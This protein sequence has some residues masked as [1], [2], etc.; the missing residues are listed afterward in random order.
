[1]NV[2]KV[3]KLNNEIIDRVDELRQELHP[4]QRRIAVLSNKSIQDMSVSELLA[5]A[6][7]LLE[8]TSDITGGH[9]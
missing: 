7:L 9:V 3:S 4:L 1:M 5:T 8:I 6:L 2:Q